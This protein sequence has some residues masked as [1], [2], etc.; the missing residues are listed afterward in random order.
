MAY[1]SNGNETFLP[2]K[3]SNAQG[4]ICMNDSIIDSFAKGLGRLG[5]TR[6]ILDNNFNLLFRIGTTL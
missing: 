1:L 4:L 2:V 6:I 3:Y 5:S